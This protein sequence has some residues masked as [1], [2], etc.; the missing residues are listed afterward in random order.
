MTLTLKYTS[1]TY[2]KFINESEQEYNSPKGEYNIPL[3]TIRNKF[4]LI[5]E[6]RNNLLNYFKYI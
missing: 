5:K 6:I 1:F 3:G 4:Y 2:T